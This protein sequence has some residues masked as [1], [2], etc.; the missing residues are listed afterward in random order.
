MNM[1]NK[2]TARLRHS[3][4]QAAAAN[5]EDDSLYVYP[6]PAQYRYEDSRYSLAEPVYQGKS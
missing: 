4:T 3:L 2:L 5:G 1:R 6:T